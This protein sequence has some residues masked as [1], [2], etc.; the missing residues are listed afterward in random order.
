MKK[1]VLLFLALSSL[2]FADVTITKGKNA[3]SGGQT[4]DVGGATS[5][6]I[7]IDVSATVTNVG[8]EIEIVNDQDEPVTAVNFEHA[9]ATGSIDG[10]TQQELK[11][12]LKVKTTNGSNGTVTGN[13]G[14]NTLT[15]T[16]NDPSNTLTANLASNLGTDADVNN[17]GTQF[18]ISSTLSNAT[19][20]A[21]ESYSSSSTSYTIIYSKSN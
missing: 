6:S 15:L 12:F 2:S 19:V 11:T 21:D 18:R 7:N 13:F 4:V 17:N 8:P 14:N 16:G 20:T 9:L 5:A 1:Y 10:Q 3:K